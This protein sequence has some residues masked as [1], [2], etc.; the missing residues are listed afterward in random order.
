M[1]LGRSKSRLVP[2]KNRPSGHA[3]AQ[4][5]IALLSVRLACLRAWTSCKSQGGSSRNSSTRLPLSEGF[6]TPGDGRPRPRREAR[7]SG[8][9]FG[10][11]ALFSMAQASLSASGSTPRTCAGPRF[12]F[13][14]F[15]PWLDLRRTA[16]ERYKQGRELRARVPREAHAE[17]HGPRDRDAVAILAESD[18]ERVPELVPERYKRMMV[19]PF[20]FLRGAAAVMATDLAHQPLAGR[21]CKPAA[22]VI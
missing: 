8:C 18:A 7:R 22:T 2:E 16:P 10:I 20:G 15:S 1:R 19:D 12:S 17:F 21:Q 14:G 11:E 6:R 3:Y 4:W 13:P 5:D 9:R